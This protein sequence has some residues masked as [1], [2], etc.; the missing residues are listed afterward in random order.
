MVA[1]YLLVAWATHIVLLGIF[2]VSMSLQA[3]RRREPF[4]FVAVIAA[5]VAMAVAVSALVR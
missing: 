4:G 5:V 1:L 2:P 3:V